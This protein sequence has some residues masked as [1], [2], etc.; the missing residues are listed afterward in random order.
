[1]TEKMMKAPLLAL[2]LIIV[3][4]VLLELPS[5]G[6]YGISWDEQTDIGIARTYVDEPGG[7][8]QG[9]RVDASNTRLPMYLTAIVYAIV[10]NTSLLTARVVSCFFG[11]LTII[12]VYAFCR[13]Q[14]D[15][16]TGVL[17][18]VLLATSPFFL[19]EPDSGGR[20]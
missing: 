2:G 11:L 4:Y 9:S 20:F 18:C 16:I 8:L 13:Q 3:L 14:F 5:L 12:A 10:G 17:A 6:R 1:M 19:P 7:W 15:R